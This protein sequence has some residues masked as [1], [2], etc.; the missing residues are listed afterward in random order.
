MQDVK[1]GM[2]VSHPVL[3]IL[4]EKSGLL[5]AHGK[6]AKKSFHSVDTRFF[7]RR[8]YLNIETKRAVL[9]A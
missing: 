2:L 8:A 6:I 4:I 3:Y 5:A 1:R 7:M 9:L